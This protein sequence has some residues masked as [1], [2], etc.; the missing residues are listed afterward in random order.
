MSVKPL[1]PLVPADIGPSWV[2]KERRSDVIARA[3]RCTILF[4]I[5][6]PSCP[7]LGENRRPTAPYRGPSR[8]TQ[9]P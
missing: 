5:F 6:S 8:F 9:A 7:F 1:T 2:P 3:F 4:T